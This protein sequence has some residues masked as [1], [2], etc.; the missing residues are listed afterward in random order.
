VPRQEPGN[1]KNLLRSCQLRLKPR[2]RAPSGEKPSAEPYR[3]LAFLP[4]DP[5]RVDKPLTADKPFTLRAASICRDLRG[6]GISG[7]QSEFVESS[8]G[9]DRR[10]RFAAKRNH[11]IRHQSFNL[12]S[13]CARS[14]SHRATFMHYSRRISN[15]PLPP[16]VARD[17]RR[18]SAGI[19]SRRAKLSLTR[20]LEY[21]E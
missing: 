19:P 9:A 6:R 2:A 20:Y 17:A 12:R 14:S 5:T 3:D 21:L 7:D 8:S 1:L 15:V 18:E 10:F 13:N 11:S 16:P 4:A